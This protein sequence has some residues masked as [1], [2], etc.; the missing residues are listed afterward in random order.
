VAKAAKY[1]VALGIAF[2]AVGAAAGFVV[3][4][5]VGPLGYEASALAALINWAAGSLALV[6]VAVG[7]NQPWR[8]HGVL[9]AMGVRMALPLAALAFFSRSEH[10]LAVA[11]VAGLIVVHY[12][13]GLVIETLMSLRLAANAAQGKKDSPQPPG[14]GTARLA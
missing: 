4:R 3:A 9:L 8:A 2:A 14:P 10:P 6:V 7:R 1:I 11:G 13:V 5:R 12:L